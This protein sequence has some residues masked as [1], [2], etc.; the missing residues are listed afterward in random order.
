MVEVAAA[1]SQRYE[2]LAS[3]TVKTSPPLNATAKRLTADEYRRTRCYNPVFAC[4]LSPVC[5]TAVEPLPDSTAI[6]NIHPEFIYE[7]TRSPHVRPFKM[8][9]N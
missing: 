4:P 7:L 5:S 8:G 1:F 9:D 2:R 6:R 3:A